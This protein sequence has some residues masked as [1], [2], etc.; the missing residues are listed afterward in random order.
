MKKRQLVIPCL[1]LLALSCGRRQ[2]RERRMELMNPRR[3]WMPGASWARRRS[4]QFFP[5]VS[6][7]DPNL[8]LVACDMTGAYISEDAGK[9]W[10]MF[11]LRH[12][13]KVLCF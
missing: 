12:P 5:E 2:F 13:G 8:V 11:N 3:V 4:A 1:A 9:S 6:P 10:R 7:H